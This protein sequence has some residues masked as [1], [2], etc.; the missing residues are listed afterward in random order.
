MTQLQQYFVPRSFYRWDSKYNK[1]LIFSFSTRTKKPVKCLYLQALGVVDFRAGLDQPDLQCIE[2]T[3]IELDDLKKQ[4]ATNIYDVSGKR[5][6]SCYLL[7]VGIKKGQVGVWFWCLGSRVPYISSPRKFLFIFSTILSP[8]RSFVWTAQRTLHA[9]TL[10][11][12]WRITWLIFVEVAKTITRE[13][14]SGITGRWEVHD[15]FLS[16]KLNPELQQH[17]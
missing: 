7:C 16:E 5:D 15:F 14:C 11:I 4:V 8:R 13:S 2:K 9:Q 1:I 3:G 10:A 6:L 12:Y 17:H